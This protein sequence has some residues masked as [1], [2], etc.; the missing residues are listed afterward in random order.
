[1]EIKKIGEWGLLPP[2]PDSCQVCGRE[3]GAEHPHDAK[4]M[5]YQTVFH[6]EHGRLPTWEDAMAH[7][8]DDMKQ[9][10]LDAMDR[11]QLELTKLNLAGAKHERS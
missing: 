9:L 10:W 8:A 5:Y 4:S 2:P 11:V 7:C 3:H 1:M 6:N